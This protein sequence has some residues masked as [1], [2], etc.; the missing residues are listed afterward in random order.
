MLR[1]LFVF[2]VVAAVLV[3][4][5]IA[6]PQVAQADCPPG[7]PVNCGSY[8]CDARSVCAGGTCCPVGYPKLC[9][10]QCCAA[11][12][13]CISGTCCPAG[14]T[15]SCG[16][17]CCEPGSVCADG[18]CCPPGYTVN[19]GTYCCEPGNICTDVGCCPQ[20]SPVDCGDYCCEKDT[21]CCEDGC[22]PTS[23][24]TCAECGEL[25]ISSVDIGLQRSANLRNFVVEAR[26]DYANCIREI[27]DGCQYTCGK[28]LYNNLPGCDSDDYNDAGHRAC[29]E[30]S[31]SGAR[32][33]C[34]R[35]QGQ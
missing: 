6:I 18:G 20:D 14:Y 33:E 34:E 11:E 3:A 4:G 23:D 32:L 29:V 26:Q 21:V 16:D 25:L 17:Y 7:Y 13:T 15:V 19:C 35:Q 1:K 12:D 28:Q 24:K 5:M 9:G 30:T 31:L 27:P 22:C 2:S 10:G 8:C